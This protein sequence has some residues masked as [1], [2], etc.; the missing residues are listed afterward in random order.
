MI[1]MRFGE[2]WR[3][4]IKGFLTSSKAS[5]LINVIST[6]EFTPSRGVRQGDPLSPFL[7]I[8]L[9]EGLSF[10]MKEACL[11]GVFQG[12]QLPNG[13][14]VVCHVLYVDDALF[15]GD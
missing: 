11:N 4:C 2:K 7:F 9:M 8:T 14:P 10:T 6:D 13:G 15:I 5:V 12:L 3:R 1:Q